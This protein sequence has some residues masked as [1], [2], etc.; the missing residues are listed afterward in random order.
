MSKAHYS[1]LLYSFP[2]LPPDPCMC[3]EDMATFLR[4]QFEVDVSRFSISRALKDAEWSKKATQNIARGCNPDLR[5]EYMREIS[6]LRSDQMVLIDESGVG[7]SIG[8]KRKGW[9]P[10][11]QA[12]S[13]RLEVPNPPCYT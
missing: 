9:A 8:T 6:S 3:L 13:L 2:T 11:S 4:I 12:I 5:D 1:I 7:R 10:S